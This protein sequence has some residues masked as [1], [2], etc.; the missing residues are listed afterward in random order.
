MSQSN[1]MQDRGFL[2]EL[3]RYRV[4]TYYA[5]ITVLDFATERPITHLQGRV[6]NGSMSISAKSATRRTGSMQI[7]FDKLTFDLTNIDNLIAINKKI[8]L[9]VGIANPFYANNMYRD[10]GDVLYFKQGTFIITNATSSVSATS[11]II[12]MQFIDKMGMLN[13]TCGG[14]LPASVS[15]HDKLIIDPDENTT[16]LYPRIKQIV[17]EVVHHFGGE[18]PSKIII[19]DIPDFGRQVATWAGATPARFAVNSGAFIV[20]N[21]ANANFPDMKII[22]DDIGYMSAELTYPGEL[23][24]KAGSTVVA[25]LD[26]IV[27]TLGNYEYFYDVDGYFHFQQ[28]KNFDKTGQAPMVGNIGDTSTPFNI[29]SDPAVDAQFQSQYLPKFQNDQFLNE[30]ATTDLVSSASLN[31]QYAN[32]KNDFIVWGSRKANK[33]EDKLVRYHL[34]IDKRPKEDVLTSLCRRNIWV[35]RNAGTKQINRYYAQVDNSGTMNIPS[36][37]EVGDLVGGNVNYRGSY[38]ATTTYKFD[39]LPDSVLYGGLYYA[40]QYT[41]DTVAGITGIAPGNTQYWRR[42]EDTAEEI[43][44]HSPSLLRLPAGAPTFDWREELY[45]RALMAYN[46]SDEGSYYDEE[47]LA[48]WRL[49]FNPNEKAADP[50]STITGFENPYWSDFHIQWDDHFAGGSLTPWTGYNVDVVRKPQNIRYWLDLIDTNSALGA[51][52]VDRIGRRTVVKEN[53]KIN[54]VLNRE[55]PDVVFIDGTLPQERIEEA[56]DEYISIGQKYCIVKA[57]YLPYFELRN[58]FGTCYEE[59]RNLLHVHLMYNASVS[60]T[61]IPMLYLDVNKV[62][63]L[64]FPELGIVGNYIINTISWSLSNMA[65]MTLQLNEAIVIA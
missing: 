25:V 12:N 24:M 15:F 3:N 28:I 6:V 22:G 23:V 35:V 46:S 45:R 36:L 41:A 32:I 39:G 10:Y 42:L 18:H 13:G 65:T 58:S 60:I 47:L 59:I 31:P 19:D 1:F 33:D 55:I 53:N 34:A 64:N 61:A 17:Y 43:L 54:E 5:I 52:S 30:F 20:S 29:S 38:S 4:K 49:I 2:Q 56:E 40:I 37:G 7:V 8:S 62:I 63:R 48:E 27:K 51:Y 57:D 14:T 16:T 21:D 11:R 26:E 9:T 44:L 50:Y